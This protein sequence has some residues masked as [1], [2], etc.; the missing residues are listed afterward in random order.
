IAACRLQ[1]WLSVRGLRFERVA[2]E[3]VS[4]GEFVT[5]EITVWSEHRIRRPLITIWDNLPPRLLHDDR[6]PSLPVAPA[7]DAGTKT[8]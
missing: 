5:V 2:P 6:S 4:I 7:F 8:Q 3:S 1:A